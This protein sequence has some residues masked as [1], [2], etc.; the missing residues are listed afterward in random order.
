MRALQEIT[1]WQSNQLP[2]SFRLLLVE[3]LHRGKVFKNEE[4]RKNQTKY[5]FANFQ[6][7]ADGE[8]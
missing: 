6:K 7:W 3:V 1:V 2:D 5:P 4:Y 8:K